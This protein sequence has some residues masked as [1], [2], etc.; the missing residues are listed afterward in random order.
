MK[1]RKKDRQTDRYGQTHK[2]SFAHLERTEH[3]ESNQTDGTYTCAKTMGFA[4]SKKMI[5]E[6]A[7]I[8]S[9]DHH[10]HMALQPNSGPG[11]PLWDFLT[12]TFLQF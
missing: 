11:L 10:H 6:H 7:G 9:K 2:V 12:V 8:H 4:G 5:A 3:L 1:E